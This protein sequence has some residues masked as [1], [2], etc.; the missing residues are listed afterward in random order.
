MCGFANWALSFVPL[1]HRSVFEP[2]PRCFDDHCSGVLP[3]VWGGLCLSICSY[4][5]D[6][7]GNTGSFMV[8]IN[9]I[10]NGSSSV[11]KKSVHAYGDQDCIK[12]VD[13]LGLWLF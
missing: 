10:I 11:K 9:F 1:I 8:H 7:F 3:E 5:Q 12:S 4:P 13:F 2:R 6:F